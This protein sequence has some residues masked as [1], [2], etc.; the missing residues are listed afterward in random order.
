M[1]RGKRAVLNELSEISLHL[2]IS[3]CCFCV[4]TKLLDLMFYPEYSI[5][6]A[7]IALELSRL[8]YESAFSVQPDEAAAP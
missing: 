5:T 4:T 1:K 7:T 8:S 3:F 6:Y 2:P